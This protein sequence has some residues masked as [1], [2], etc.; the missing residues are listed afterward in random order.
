MSPLA[1]M[2]SPSDFFHPSVFSILDSKRK[3]RMN[4]ITFFLKVLNASTPG[5]GTDRA[6]LKDRPNSYLDFQL[7]KFSAFNS[8]KEKLPI[9][10]VSLKSQGSFFSDL[11][12]PRKTVGGWSDEPP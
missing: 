8:I 3:R 7:S 9:D 5:T 12:R 6:F 4:L 11:P 2:K 1:K 10:D